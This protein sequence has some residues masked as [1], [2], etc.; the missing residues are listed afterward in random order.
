VEASIGW[1]CQGVELALVVEWRRGGGGVFTAE[2]N[3]SDTR[4]NGPHHNGDTP[5]GLD[6]AATPAAAAGRRKEREGN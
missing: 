5:E 3:G 6:G 1:R 4:C 2:G